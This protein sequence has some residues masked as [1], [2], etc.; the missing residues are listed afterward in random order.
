[1]CTESQLFSIEKTIMSKKDLYHNAHLVVAAIR[2]LEHQ[3]NMPP[4]VETLQK[5]LDFS[6]EECHFLCRKLHQLGVIDIVEGSFGAKLFIKNHLELENIPK[7]PEDSHI[8]EDIDRFMTSR[9]DYSKEIESI[10]AQQE[11]KQKDLF[12]RIDEKLKKNLAGKP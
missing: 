2:L 12:A 10:K 7:M 1:M 3:R 9:K 8:R 5:T 4:D 6:L 11:K